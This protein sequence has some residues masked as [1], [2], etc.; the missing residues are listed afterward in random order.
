MIKKILTLFTI[1]ALT[2][3]ASIKEKMPK[4]QACTG[5][6]TGKTVAEMLCKKS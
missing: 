3:C 6:E 5:D 2:S 4:R 1:I